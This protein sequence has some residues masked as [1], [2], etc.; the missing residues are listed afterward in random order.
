MRKEDMNELR[1]TAFLEE[2]TVEVVAEKKTRKKGQAPTLEE[3]KDSGKPKTGKAANS[4]YV[5]VRKA[6]SSSAQVVTT[7]NVG[8]QAQI[9]NRIPGY[10]EVRVLKNGHVGF[11]ASNYFRED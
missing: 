11:V 10:Y 4:R 5:R 8:D 6:P 3:P 9:L 1:E 2:E 7:M